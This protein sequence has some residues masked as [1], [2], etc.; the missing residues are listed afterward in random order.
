M[1]PEI[2][3]ATYLECP[4][5]ERPWP[6]CECLTECLDSCPVC[7]LEECNGHDGSKL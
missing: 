7:G 4:R 6:A 3:D 5:C 1:N 2:L